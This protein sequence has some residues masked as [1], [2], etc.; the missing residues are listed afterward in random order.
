MPILMSE[1]QARRQGLL[2]DV[3]RQ[4]QPKEWVANGI[5]MDSREEVEFAI[6]GHLLLAGLLG[7]DFWITTYHDAQFQFLGV[8]YTPDFQLYD[9]EEEHYTWVEVK[10]PIA[11]AR[12]GRSSLRSL[13]QL[14]NS[15]PQDKCILAE[16]TF[17]RDRASWR[18]WIVPA[19]GRRKE[20]R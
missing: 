2:R 5:R 1:R 16:C 12:E 6:T 19:T 13:K 10:G 8:T 15:Y 4:R 9:E 3:K 18:F 17:K 11:Y 7:L 20:L 14:A